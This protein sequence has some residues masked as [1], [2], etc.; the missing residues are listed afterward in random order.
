MSPIIALLLIIVVLALPLAISI[1]F[2]HSK[3]DQRDITH[4]GK[5][6]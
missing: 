2:V 3:G 1:W 4:G 6:G 5:R